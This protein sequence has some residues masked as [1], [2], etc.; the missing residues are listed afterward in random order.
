MA[1]LGMVVVV[2]YVQVC[3]HDGN[4]VCSVLCVQVLTVFQSADLCQ[5]ICF[6]G[7][8]QLTEIVSGANALKEQEGKRA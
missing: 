8:L 4:I 2:R 6:I 5:R 7:L 1:V 3:R